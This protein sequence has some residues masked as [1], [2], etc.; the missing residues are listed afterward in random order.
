MDFQAI[1]M[2]LAEEVCSLFASSFLHLFLFIAHTVDP[3]HPPQVRNMSLMNAF[4]CYFNDV[5]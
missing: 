5:R 4:F 3:P 1:Q 2:F